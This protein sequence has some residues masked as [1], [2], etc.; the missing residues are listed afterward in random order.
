MA[1]LAKKQLRARKI[2]HG[3]RD[4]ASSC[5]L[6][7]RKCGV[8]RLRGERGYCGCG[9]RPVVYSAMS[10][11][12]EE[13]PISG[14]RGSGAIFF[15]GCG[16]K[17]VYCQN[18]IFSHTMCGREMEPDVLGDLMLGLQA[19]GCHNINLVNPTFS[20]PGVIEALI[21]AFSEGLN[22][23]V[24]YNTGGYDSLDVIKHLEGLVDI[25]LPDIRYSTNVEA[26]RYSKAPCYMEKSRAAVKEMWRQTGRLETAEGIAVKGLIIRLLVLPGNI[27]GTEGSLKF[28]AGEMGSDI[29]VSLMSQYR[30]LYKA[31]RFK[32]LNREITRAEYEREVRNLEKYCLPNGWTQPFGVDFDNDLLGENFLPGI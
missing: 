7:P 21:Y 10:H 4:L 2:L 14:F 5:S 15:S 6:C 16:M 25:Y 31:F 26:E 18:H 1:G 12:G 30:P 24:V 22:I 29:S 9:S 23:P 13:P 28:I 3:I 19:K 11:P 32:E 20:L 8:D 27:S 17:C